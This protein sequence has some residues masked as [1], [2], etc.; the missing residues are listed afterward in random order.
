VG[1]SQVACVVGRHSPRCGGAARRSSQQRPDKYTQLVYFGVF[2]GVFPVDLGL[3]MWL[4]VPSW[5]CVAR[6]VGQCCER[7]PMPPPVLEPRPWPGGAVFGEG[8]FCGLLGASPRAKFAQKSSSRSL[9]A[10]GAQVRGGRKAV[11]AKKGRLNASPGERGAP[12][13][14]ERGHATGR[15][16]QRTRWQSAYVFKNSLFDSR[17][18]S[19]LGKRPSAHTHRAVKPR[20]PKCTSTATDQMEM[21][22][23][24]KQ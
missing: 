6:R 10:P 3:C 4:F 5:C 18:A 9:L 23:E 17:Q 2:L 21:K 20:T 1:G 22:R 7:H 15:A 16:G 12:G 13:T 24:D 8:G 19:A 11:G 14:R